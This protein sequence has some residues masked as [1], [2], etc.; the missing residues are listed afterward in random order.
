[1]SF[2][3]SS[4]FKE[5]QTTPKRWKDIPTT[6][7]DFKADHM[8]T[9]EELLVTEE[10]FGPE[11]HAEEAFMAIRPEAERP[12]CL[13]GDE[14]QSFQIMSTFNESEPEVPVE[15]EGPENVI[16]SQRFQPSPEPQASM[17]KMEQKPP[18]LKKKSHLKSR[19]SKFLPSQYPEVPV[20]ITTL[21]R[22]TP[23]VPDS[24][25]ETEVD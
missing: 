3:E 25:I 14:N 1:M 2:N 13:G 8:V 9:Q 21:G 15:P 20:I 10:S 6:E 11:V 19:I 5:V 23:E 17:V 12:P 18:L 7:S 24:T 4:N 22:E 16:Y